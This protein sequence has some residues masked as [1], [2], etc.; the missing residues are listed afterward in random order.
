M[1]LAVFVVWAVPVLLVIRRIRFWHK[2]GERRHAKRLQN[3]A[4][5]VA[6]ALVPL[7][8]ATQIFLL[9]KM[10]LAGV[11]TVLPLH[12]CSFMGVLTPFML[13]TRSTALLEFTLYLGVP[14]ALAA[15]IFPAVM[16]SPWPL[17]MEGA[18]FSM[19]ALIVLAP[20]LRMA[21]GIRPRPLAL[22]RVFLWGNILL[23]MVMGVNSIFKTNYFF[24]RNAPTGTPL[25]LLQ[26]LGQAAYIS[27]LEITALVLLKLETLAF[28]R[29]AK[30]KA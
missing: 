5:I 1:S 22:G 20:F 2:V 11:G 13:L 19:H 14:G 23:L 8:M 29:V 25:Y 24:L 28:N 9:W 16:P 30:Q 6:A 12:L 26:N 7:C 27:T 10:G 3:A 15:L 21:N 18:F 4:S 17:I